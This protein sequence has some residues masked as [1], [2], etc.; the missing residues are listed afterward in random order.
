MFSYYGGKGNVIDFYPKPKFN[1]IIEPFAGS[2]KYALKYF[3]REVLLVDKYEVIVKIW[4]WLQKCSPKDILSL[5]RPKENERLSTFNFDCEEAKLLMGFIIAKGGQCPRDKPT[6]RAT[7]HRPNTS[8]FTLNRIASDLFKIKHWEIRLGSYNEIKTQEAT[9]YIDPPYQHGGH[10]YI[11]SNKKIDFT[12]LSKWCQERFGQVIVSE[13]SKA[14]W[15]PFKKM[16]KMRGNIHQTTEVIWSNMP[17]NYD[18]VQHP[19]F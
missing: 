19:L 4:K 15:L 18:T 11:H 1:K 10:V 2:A 14:D 5:P 9:W 17:T 8:N 16:A 13:N 3:D 7:T 12:D 6:S